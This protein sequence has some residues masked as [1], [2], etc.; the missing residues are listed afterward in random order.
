MKYCPFCGAGVHS[1]AVSFCSECGKKLVTA[2]KPCPH[3]PKADP[4]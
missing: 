4:D 2:Q 1:G 3:A